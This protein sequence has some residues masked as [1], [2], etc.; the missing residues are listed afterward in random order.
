MKLLIDTTDTDKLRLEVS[1]DKGKR[2]VKTTVSAFR[3]QGEKLLPSLDRLLKRKSWQLSDIKAIT[4]VNGQGSFSGLR[5]GIATANALAYIL[6]VSVVDDQGNCL[7]TD[8]LNIVE[9]YY[10]AE[11]NIG[12]NKPVDN[13]KNI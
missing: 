1:D 5:I 10:T 4:V 9:P 11:P 13:Q 7:K 6:G 8:D 2:L 3:K 12:G